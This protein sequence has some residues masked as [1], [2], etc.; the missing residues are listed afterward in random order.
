VAA[1]AEH[2]I[3]VGRRGATVLTDPNRRTLSQLLASEE[4]A[5]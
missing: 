2:T 5:D 4:C 3:A 1:H